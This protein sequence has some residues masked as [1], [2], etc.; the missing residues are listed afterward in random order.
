MNITSLEA[1]IRIGIL[2]AE[3]LSL[4]S[5][6]KLSIEFHARPTTGK[7]RLGRFI[8]SKGDIFDGEY[9]EDEVALTRYSA[10]GID[11]DFYMGYSAMF[12]VLIIATW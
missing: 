1:L 7:I 9:R 8:V 2:A 5:V 11:E 3:T 12:H 10:V 6:D 4:T